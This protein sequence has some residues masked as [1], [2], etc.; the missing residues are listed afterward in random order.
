MP[1]PPESS[2]TKRNG[3]FSHLGATLGRFRW[4][5][6]DGG[7]QMAGEWAVITSRTIRQG[8]EARGYRPGRL[9]MTVSQPASNWVG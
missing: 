5:S 7:A 3:A 2:V 9:S 4:C 1:T 6:C 8:G